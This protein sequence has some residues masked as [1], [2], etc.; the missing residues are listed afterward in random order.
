MTLEPTRKPHGKKKGEG[1]FRTKCCHGPPKTNHQ[2]LIFHI[3]QVQKCIYACC[4]VTFTTHKSINFGGR[5]DHDRMVVRFSTTHAI[6]VYHHW[7]SE[8]ESRPGR[9]VQYYVIKFVSDLRQVGGFFMVL[10]F[11]PPIKLTTRIQL[12]HQTNKQTQFRPVL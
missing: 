5:R 12:K 8:L 10:R 3:L 9:G 7:C 2:L 11:F 1:V 6:S 4:A